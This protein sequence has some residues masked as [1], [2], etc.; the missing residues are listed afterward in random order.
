MSITNYTELQAAILNFTHRSDLGATI[1]DFIRLAEDMIYGDIEFRQQDTSATLTCT[2][3]SESVALPIDFID[4]L[5]LTV[6]SVTPHG[7][8]D[9]R[10]IDQYKQEFQYGDSGVP[11]IYTLIGSNIMLQPI[12]DQAYTLNLVYQAKFSN[13]SASNTANALLINY[14]SIYLYGSLTHAAI[15]MQDENQ[16]QKWHDLYINT[17]KNLNANDWANANT[18][19]VKTDI[20]LTAYRP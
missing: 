7:T 15:Y 3:L 2:A 12:P 17:L 5:S 1:P 18:M 14:P 8:I 19:T 16:E 20:S 11:R 6:S 9:Y 10:A 4:S 13:L